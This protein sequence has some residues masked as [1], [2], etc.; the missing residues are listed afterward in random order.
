MWP[1]LDVSSRALFEIDHGNSQGQLRD[2]AAQIHLSQNR[3]ALSWSTKALLL[4]SSD[5]RT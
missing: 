2:D 3:A 4:L 1:Y 5:Q